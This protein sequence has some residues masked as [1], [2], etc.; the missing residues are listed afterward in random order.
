MFFFF[1]LRTFTNT[2][3]YCDQELTRKVVDH[4]QGIPWMTLHVKK[5]KKI[6]NLIFKFLS[7]QWN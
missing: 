3:K 7:T 1:W 6:S 4:Q 2:K 5:K